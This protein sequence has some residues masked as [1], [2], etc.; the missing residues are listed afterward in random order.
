MARVFVMGPPRGTE[1][2][3]HEEKTRAIRI[4]PLNLSHLLMIYE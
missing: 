4:H 3:S 2:P 1:E